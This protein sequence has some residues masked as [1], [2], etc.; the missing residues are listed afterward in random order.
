MS[1]RVKTE[2][3]RNL[4]LHSSFFTLH[5]IRVQKYKLSANI[6]IDRLPNLLSILQKL[7]F[8]IDITEL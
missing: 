6:P 3:L 2:L 4:I 5:L 7:K 8:L 1:E